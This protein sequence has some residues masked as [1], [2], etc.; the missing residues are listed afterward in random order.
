MIVITG[1]T[2]FIG[3]CLAS[4]LNEERYYDLVLVDD[5]SH[6]EKNRSFEGKRIWPQRDVRNYLAAGRVF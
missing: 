5:F 3:S 6:P 4:K 2:G 1:A